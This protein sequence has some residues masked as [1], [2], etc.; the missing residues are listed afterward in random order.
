MSEL[1]ISREEALALLRQHVANENLVKHCLAAEAIMRA[2]APRLDADPETLGIVGLVHDIDFESTKD[3]PANHTL[4]GAEIL[5]EAGF[6]DELIRLIQ[7]HNAEGLGRERSTPTEHALAAAETIT[8]LIVATALVYP[9][10]K[11]ASVKPKSV[12]KRMKKKDFARAVNRDV[13]LECEKF[14]MELPEFV[15]LSLEAM[16]GIATELGL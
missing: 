2:L 16:Q 13:I 8:G 6:P 3:D 12:L 11:I 4:K 7:S 15:Q 1:T 14:G 10:K 5:S 9:D